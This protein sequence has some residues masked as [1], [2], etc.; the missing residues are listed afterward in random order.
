MQY[1]NGYPNNF[2]QNHS[3][4]A[5]VN[6]MMS[7]EAGRMVKLYN[8]LGRKYFERTKENPD[9]EFENIFNEIKTCKNRIAEYTETLNRLKGIKICVECGAQINIRAPFCSVCG[10]KQSQQVATP[11]NG[12]KF[13]TNCG[14]AII[15]NS[16]FCTTCGTRVQQANPTE[17][18]SVADPEMPAPA[19]AVA[20]EE[21]VVVP[22]EPI[23]PVAIE[24]KAFAPDLSNAPAETEMLFSA[25]PETNEP[26]AETTEYEELE[27]A[28][29]QDTAQYEELEAAAPQDTA[30]YEELEA[31]APQDTAQYEELEAAAPEDTTQYEQAE[32]SA[33]E[34]PIAPIENEEDSSA[35]PVIEQL[36]PIAA[37]PEETTNLCPNCGSA[38][39]DGYV[40]CTNCGTRLSVEPQNPVEPEPAIEQSEP[41][42]AEPTVVTCYNC[43]AQ[44]EEGLS[45]CTNCGANL[46]N[47][48]K[49]DVP[50]DKHCP[51]CHN[52]VADNSA[53]CTNCGTKL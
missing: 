42:V 5:R 31:A 52:V 24:P 45:F 23:A 32:L 17:T 2:G 44:L 49:A 22:V 7:M 37:E 36:E 43:G 39:D 3:E 28:A 1:Y 35:E 26:F 25:E 34:E 6:N 40:F 38:F 48:P 46:A 53:F 41:I 50:G 10:A 29:P 11:S 4:I 13:C 14:T 33:P 30:Q 27:A 20:V 21:P 15:N 47:V 16:A 19:E 18:V 51:N 9:S 12:Q 8:E